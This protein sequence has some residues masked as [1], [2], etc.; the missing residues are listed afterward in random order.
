[1]G[2]EEYVMVEEIEDVLKEQ[3]L[4]KGYV[5]SCNWIEDN[6]KDETTLG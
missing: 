2:W 6:E 3:L 4:A 5:C 1:M